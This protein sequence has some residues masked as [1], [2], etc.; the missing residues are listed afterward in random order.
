MA[1]VLDISHDSRMGRQ[2]ETYG[3]DPAIA[4]ALGSAF[5]RGLQGGETGG[6]RTESVAKHFLGFHAS[7][8]GIHGT[9]CEITDHTLRELYAK[10]F[11]AAITEAG[12]RGVMLQYPQ[13]AEAV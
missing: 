4:S 13:R 10:P 11:Q 1:P 8:G 6:R 5:V 12:L 3:E 2:G 9:V 7:E